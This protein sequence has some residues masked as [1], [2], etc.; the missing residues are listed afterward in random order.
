MASGHLRLE[1]SEAIGWNQFPEFAEKFTT[2][3]GVPVCKKADGIEMC[4]W[5]LQFPTCQLALVF[6]DFPVMVSLES[7]SIQGDDILKNL[8]EQL[9]DRAVT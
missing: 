4:I 5:D 2:L 8:A 3:L 1:L 9:K 7:D 6:D